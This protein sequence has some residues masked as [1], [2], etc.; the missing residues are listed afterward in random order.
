MGEAKTALSRRS[1]L[2]TAGAAGALA[3]AGA[4]TGCDG[5][6]GASTQGAAEEKVAYTFHMR[7]CQCQCHLKCTVRDGRLVLVEPNK[8]DDPVKNTICLK[9]LAEVQYVYSNER[10]QSPLKRVGERG[11][12]EFEAIS[13]DEALDIIVEEYK[14]AVEKYG[15]VGTCILPATDGLHVNLGKI[16]GGQQNPS[17]G[18]NLGYGN[19]FSP[20]LAESGRQGA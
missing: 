6:L 18:V 20:A 1:F 19:G 14:K 4:M 7:H 9:G 10:L 17:G 5:W 16:I 12:G 11:K 2:K 15:K 13:W 8:W 3:A